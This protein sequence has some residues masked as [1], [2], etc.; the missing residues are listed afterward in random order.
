M[1]ST[2]SVGNFYRLGDRLVMQQRHEDGVYYSI[3]AAVRVG[4]EWVA[5]YRAYAESVSRYLSLPV[6]V[7]AQ[8]QFDRAI[9]MG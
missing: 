9:L 3:V 1:R 7:V 5:Q 8:R 4:G 2:D 6:R